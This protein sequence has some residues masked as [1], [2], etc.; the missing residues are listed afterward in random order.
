M[1]ARNFFQILLPFVSQ[2]PP[3]VYYF[4]H[5]FSH[6][7]SGFNIFERVGSQCQNYIGLHDFCFQQTLHI[8]LIY[9]SLLCLAYFIYLFIFFAEYLLCRHL[10]HKYIHIYVLYYTL[11]V[12]SHAPLICNLVMCWY[13]VGIICRALPSSRN[14][15][16]IWYALLVCAAVLEWS[17]CASNM[18]SM[19]THLMM[20]SSI[21]LA[22]IS[23]SLCQHLELL[24]FVYIII[25]ILCEDLDHL[26]R[27]GLKIGPRKT[28][29]VCALGLKSTIYKIMSLFSM[30]TT[31]NA[32]R[33][34]F[35]GM[36]VD[37]SFNG[38]GT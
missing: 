37:G 16:K 30:T 3:I 1:E 8:V 4:I 32:L 19:G 13:H 14:A 20:P 38:K 24:F 18:L 9:H 31:T 15:S 27:Y 33:L 17:Y 21:N 22:S 6:L 29:M 35:E 23:G 2:T 36:H 11:F 25:D 26:R 34:G 5:R 7:R 12:F 28:K 10:N